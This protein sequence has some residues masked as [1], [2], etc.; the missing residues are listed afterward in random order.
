[1]SNESTLSVRN[2]QRE[3]RELADRLN[4][5]ASVTGYA[6]ELSGRTN[7]PDDEKSSEQYMQIVTERT[8]NLLRDLQSLFQRLE[9]TEHWSK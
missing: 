4:G 6:C 1:M 5:I 2:T 3:L 9:K 8:S 7:N